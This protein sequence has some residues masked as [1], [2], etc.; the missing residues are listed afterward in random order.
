MFEIFYDKT[1]DEAIKNQM[2][3]NLINYATRETTTFRKN[4]RKNV[5][6]K[7]MFASSS[8]TFDNATD[9]RILSLSF[10]DQSRL[11]FIDQSRFSLIDQ[12]RFST[13]QLRLSLADQ[14]RLSLADQL[15][16]SFAN[17][18]RL[19]LANQLR[20]LL[21]NQLRLSFTNISMNL[22]RSYTKDDLSTKTQLDFLIHFS[23]QALSRTLVCVAMWISLQLL[24]VKEY[25]NRWLFNSLKTTIS[26]WLFILL[27]SLSY[28]TMCRDRFWK[29]SMWR[30]RW[31]LKKNWFK[32]LI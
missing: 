26:I 10:T 32:W 20:L 27:L 5:D 29:I 12:S 1:Y 24:L 31:M 13:D 3:W 30:C 16:L 7:T 28:L 6:E 4:R 18:L 23:L 11:S 14:L 9:L 19:L 2:I 8:N 17:Q 25:L 22:N 15:K 21:A